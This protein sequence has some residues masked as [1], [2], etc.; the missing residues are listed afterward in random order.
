VVITPE[1]IRAAYAYLAETPPFLNWH[2]PDAED[3]KFTVIGAGKFY[4]RCAYP[5]TE[6]V[7]YQIDISKAYHTHTATLMKTIA[8]EMVHVHMAQAQMGWGH[9][10]TFK[11]LAKEVC[12]A[13]GFDIGHF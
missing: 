2:M 6:G 4:G 7:P 1:I 11:A 5:A 12:D 8:H 3:V 10:K 9:G 13:H